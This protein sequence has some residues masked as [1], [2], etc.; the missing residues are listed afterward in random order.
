[1]SISIK[2]INSCEF[3]TKI[4]KKAITSHT[5]FIS[6]EKLNQLTDGKLSKEELLEFSIKFLLDRENNTSILDVFAIEDILKYYPEYTETLNNFISG[7][8][9]DI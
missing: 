1:M 6:D 7:K 8:V 9:V 5:I 3:E 4:V 2:K